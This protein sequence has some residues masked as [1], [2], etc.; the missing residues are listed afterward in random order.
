MIF[1]N[2]SNIEENGLLTPTKPGVSLQPEELEIE[3][4]KGVSYSF[5]K[6]KNWSEKSQR[7]RA[8]VSPRCPYQGCEH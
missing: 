4:L 8:I 1:R 2:R 3:F 7:T 5:T 6:M